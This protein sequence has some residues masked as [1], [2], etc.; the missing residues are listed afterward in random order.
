VKPIE[1][2]RQ[3]AEKFIREHSPNY[4]KYQDQLT[5]E[6]GGK[7]DI[8]FFT[9]RL[10]DKDWSATDWKMMPP[11]LQIGMSADG[12]IATLIDTLDL[13]KE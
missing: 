6:Q 8:Y 11:F 9:W 10:K 12:K 5:F 13:Y 3:I 1:T 2:V 4:G 7:G